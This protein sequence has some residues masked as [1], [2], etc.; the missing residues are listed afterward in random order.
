M[1]IPVAL[2]KHNER[3]FTDPEAENERTKE[4]QAENSVLRREIADCKEKMINDNK[5]RMDLERQVGFN[6]SRTGKI[7]TELAI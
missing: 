7:F 4:L 2:Q 3:Q 1:D 5:I 6:F